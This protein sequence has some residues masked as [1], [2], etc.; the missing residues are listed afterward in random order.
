MSTIV[1]VM[2]P[3]AGHTNASFK[4]ARELKSKG[5][6][7]Y[8]LAIPDFEDYVGSQGFGVLP[9]F[10]SLYPEGFTSQDVFK[11]PGFETLDAFKMLI[12]ARAPGGAKT[13]VDL[14]ASEVN[15]AI[16]NQKPDLFVVD[17]LLPEIAVAA[18]GC[19]VPVVLL[20]TNLDNHV[21]ENDRL[22]YKYLFDVPELILCP[23]RFD[24]PRER[25]KGRRYYY[26]EASIDF[27]RKQTTFPWHR[28]DEHKPLVYCSLGSQSHLLKDGKAFLQTVIDALSLREGMQMILTT[29]SHLSPEDFH[30]VPPNV[31]LA[32][33]APQIEVL[34]RASVMIG[35]GGFNSVKEC[36]Y[37]GV[38][39]IVFPLIRDHPMISARVEYHSLGLRGNIRTASP[40]SV[41]SLIDEIEKDGSFK[42]RVEQMGRYFRE[43]EK[44]GVGAEMIE[45]FL[46]ERLPCGLT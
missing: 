43:V 23:K 5:H 31:I 33:S 24:F 20:S 10:K 32:R 35:H 1:F 28:L 15:D 14:L 18:K 36:I 3:E 17:T 26:V 13:V 2:L 25:A 19:R 7:V 22:A 9:L 42:A 41:L 8:Y 38:P 4:I 6:R 39:M 16:R 12:E 11:S 40:Q 29:G 45:G 46:A 37:F 44:S 27:E 34:K 21:D 30:P